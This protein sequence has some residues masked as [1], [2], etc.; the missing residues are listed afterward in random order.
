[1]LVRPPD[2]GLEGVPEG[3]VLIARMP[4]YG[5]RDAGRGLWRR[6]RAEFRKEG[7]HEKSCGKAER[8]DDRRDP[9]GR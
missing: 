7:L 5:T 4:V 2:D 6:L 9:H 3:G 8:E 1:M